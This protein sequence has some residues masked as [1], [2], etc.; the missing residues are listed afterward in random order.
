MTKIQHLR[1]KQM[2]YRFSDEIA[3][4]YAVLWKA[5]DNVFT[6]RES[7]RSRKVQLRLFIMSV[8]KIVH[9]WQKGMKI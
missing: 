6:M 5:T 8:Y 2:N 4:H 1:I 9:I 7:C 3:K